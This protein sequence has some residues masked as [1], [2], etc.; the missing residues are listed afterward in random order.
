MK[1]QCKIPEQSSTIDHVGPTINWVDTVYH[2]DHAELQAVF[3]DDMGNVGHV[4]I[5]ALEVLC[6]GD[7]PPATGEESE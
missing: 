2:P 3:I 5:S 6:A 1:V 7:I 4:R